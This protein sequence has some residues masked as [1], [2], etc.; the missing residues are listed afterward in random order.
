VYLQHPN[1]EQ[2]WPSAEGFTGEFIFVISSV[3]GIGMHTQGEMQTYLNEYLENMQ[4]EEYKEDRVY[5][6]FPGDSEL[7][8]THFQWGNERH[9]DGGVFLDVKII[10]TA[11]KVIVW[12]GTAHVPL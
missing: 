7:D 6:K 5:V 10:T 12:E 11:E 1:L 9:D 2:V 3:A 4:G 8:P